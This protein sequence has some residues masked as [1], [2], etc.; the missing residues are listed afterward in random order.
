LSEVVHLFGIYVLANPLLSVMPIVLM[1]LPGY[2]TSVV[3]SKV[4]KV[5]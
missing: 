2:T 4:R 3:I 1:V 5:R